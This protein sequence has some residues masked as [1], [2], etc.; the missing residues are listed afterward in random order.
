MVLT[1]AG[2]KVPTP[3]VTDTAGIV[4]PNIYADIV[5]FG[6]TTWKPSVAVTNNEGLLLYFQLKPRPG[7]VQPPRY[8]IN[9]T[10]L[11]SVSHGETKEFT[12]YDGIT[13]LKVNSPAPGDIPAGAT[14]SETCALRMMAFTDA[15][16]SVPFGFADLDVTFTWIDSLS[17]G[18][19]VV[20]DNNFDDGTKQGWGYRVVTLSGGPLSLQPDDIVSEAFNS[21]PY[22]YRGRTGYVGTSPT[23]Y[24]YTGHYKSF[25]I[26]AVT[27]AFAVVYLRT[28]QQSPAPPGVCDYY[29]TQAMVGGV[30]KFQFS[31]PTDRVWFKVVVPLPLGV[32]SEV[33]LRH[34]I[35]VRG[36]G[37]YFDH[38]IDSVKVLQS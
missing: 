25:T 1:Y 8:T 12:N 4:D 30:A 13:C 33:E 6:D 19:T 2:L 38:Y 21:P 36:V 29:S 34:Y 27:R 5:E 15:G 3:V 14:L 10:N 35:A 22:S 18:W 9:T 28:K 16:Y 11:G 26:G 17:G 32:A 23:W 24:G 37:V 7:A 31:R 20:A